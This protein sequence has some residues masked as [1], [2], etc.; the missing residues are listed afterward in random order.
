MALM[1][2]PVFFAEER[3]APADVPVGYRFNPRSEE[4]GQRRTL[5]L[6]WVKEARGV[7]GSRLKN[8]VS[9]RQID[10]YNRRDR[11][12]AGQ[13]T[14]AAVVATQTAGVVTAYVVGV[15]DRCRV[16]WRVGVGHVTRMAIMMMLRMISSFPI[17]GRRCHSVLTER[18]RHGRVA[19]QR[20]PQRDQYRQDGFPA[21]HALSISHRM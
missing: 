1:K 5:K 15:G 19:L 17:R 8:S 21:I 2:R 9:D 7:G 16:I 11:R 10:R 18:H 14:S 20:Q 4:R 12:R 6:F 3:T 13:M